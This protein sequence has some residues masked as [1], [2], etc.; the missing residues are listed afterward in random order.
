MVKKAFLFPTLCYGGQKVRVVPPASSGTSNGGDSVTRERLQE[1][2]DF[3]EF[4]GNLK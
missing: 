1:R 3:T 2:G 4:G